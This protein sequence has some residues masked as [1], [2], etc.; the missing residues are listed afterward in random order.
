MK[1][2]IT[3]ITAHST[4]ICRE[5]SLTSG[6]VLPEPVTHSAAPICVLSPQPDTSLHCQTTDTGL[7]YYVVCL[8]TPQLS[9][10]LVAPTHEGTA[11]LS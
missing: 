5:V 11:R 8:F 10:I 9:L 4:E 3:I 6:K 7:V 1:F 2:K